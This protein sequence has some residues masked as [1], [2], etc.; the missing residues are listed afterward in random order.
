MI[1]EVGNIIQDSGAVVPKACQ[2]CK[3]EF[4]SSVEESPKKENVPFYQCKEC[5]FNNAGN[6]QALEH[7]M[8]SGHKINKTVRERI[9]GFDRKVKSESLAHVTTKVENGKTITSI[10]CGGCFAE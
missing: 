1:D 5:N 6:D 8:T 2:K 10:L 3:K 9:V 7:M 4:T